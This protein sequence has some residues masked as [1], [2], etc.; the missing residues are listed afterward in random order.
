MLLNKPRRLRIYKLSIFDAFTGEE[1]VLHDAYKKENKKGD[2]AVLKQRRDEK[3]ASYEGIRKIDRKKL[4]AYDYDKNHKPVM[5][6]ERENTDKQIALFENEVAR[7]ANDFKE[8]FPLVMEIVY[9][10]YI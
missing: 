6:T 1:K 10:H 9:F 4:Y 8:E 2:K 7:Y 5:S 3:L